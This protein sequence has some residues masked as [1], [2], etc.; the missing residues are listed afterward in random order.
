M[1]DG[2]SECSPPS[3]A[4]RIAALCPA[5][6]RHGVAHVAGILQEQSMDDDSD[7][8]SEEH[9]VTESP[10]AAVGDWLDSLAAEEDTFDEAF[11]ACVFPKKHADAPLCRANERLAPPPCLPVRSLQGSLSLVSPS[12]AATGKLRVLSWNCLN[13][14]RQGREAFNSLCQSR[15]P[16]VI[17]LQEY[18]GQSCLPEGYIIPK[19]L[20]MKT[21]LRSMGRHWSTVALRADMARLVQSVSIWGKAHAGFY[22]RVALHGQG[23]YVHC[24]SMHPPTHGCPQETF[25]SF[26]DDVQSDMDLH[27][28]P[29]DA[30]IAGGDFNLSPFGGAGY[31]SARTPEWITEDARRLAALTALG[32]AAPSWD[33]AYAYGGP[34]FTRAES[35]SSR[36]G[37]PRYRVGG[38]NKKFQECVDDVASAIL[39]VPQD[40]VEQGDVEALVETMHV[41]IQ[42]HEKERG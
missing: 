6:D 29:G 26:M 33:D 40:C 9:R 31:S 23:G 2:G 21:R 30:V 18:T 10:P 36:M 16:H 32:L 27:L 3:L 14:I 42:R 5:L 35:L 37:V 12:Q 24:M 38:N 13:G 22:A 11:E 1:D 20:H 4:D 39:H 8:E 34:Q 7:M 41:A 17:L 28:M 15:L 25:D 19:D